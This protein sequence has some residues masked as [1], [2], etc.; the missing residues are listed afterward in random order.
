MSCTS[1]FSAN[2]LSSL[3]PIV[4]TVHTAATISSTALN[5]TALLT[6][7]DATEF[8]EIQVN[9]DQVRHTYTGTTP[10]AATGF[11]ILV[12]ETRTLSRSQWLNSKFI[13][14]TLDATLQIAQLRSA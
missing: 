11:L 9:T 6:L 14:V 3:K 13:R 10:T 2:D 4:G 8:V 7:N 1:S 12:N 5:A